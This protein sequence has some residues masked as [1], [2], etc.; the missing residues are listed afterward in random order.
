VIVVAVVAETRVGS[1]FI[2]T[3]A[4][5]E[6]R[7]E[8]D[9]QNLHSSISRSQKFNLLIADLSRLYCDRFFPIPFTQLAYLLVTKLTSEHRLATQKLYQ[10]NLKVII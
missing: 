5:E 4:K 7:K 6:G 8:R 3:V 1:A 10:E 2:L 9:V